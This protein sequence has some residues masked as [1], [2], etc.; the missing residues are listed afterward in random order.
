MMAFIRK[1]DWLVLID[2]KD[3]YPQILMHLELRCQFRRGNPGPH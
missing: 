1:E 2:L 3:V